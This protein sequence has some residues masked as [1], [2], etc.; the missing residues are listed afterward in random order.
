[1]G[2]ARY[3]LGLEITKTINEIYVNQRKYMYDILKGVG[4]LGAKPKSTPFP[5]GQQLHSDNSPL[6]EDPQQ[7]R[8]IVG[9]HYT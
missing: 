6:L 1:M 2:D 4:L 9:K 5:K 8:S 3:F 7:Y